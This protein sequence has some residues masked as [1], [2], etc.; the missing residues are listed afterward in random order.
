MK[1][2]KEGTAATQSNACARNE[3]KQSGKPGR[4][5]SGSKKPKNYP[6]QGGKQSNQSE[7]AQM[8]P[9]LR[10]IQKENESIARLAGSLKKKKK[11]KRRGE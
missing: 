5:L 9:C 6:N 10:Q 1:T 3:I 4:R 8:S 7:E 2:R 11:K